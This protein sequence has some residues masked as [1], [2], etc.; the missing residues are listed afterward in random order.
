MKRRLPLILFLFC[1]LLAYP[2][3]AAAGTVTAVINT[4]SPLDVIAGEQFAIEMTAKNT[5]ADPVEVVLSGDSGG[6]ASIVASR[7]ITLGAEEE[8]KVFLYGTTW[9]PGVHALRVAVNG[10]PQGNELLIRVTD[11]VLPPDT[12]PSLPAP[13]LTVSKVAFR[14]EVPDLNSS[15]TI[16]ITFKNSSSTEARNVVVSLD[17][18]KNFEVLTLTNKVN[19]AYAWGGSTY[20]ASYTIRAKPDRE[21]NMVD[22][23][24]A[25]Q[26]EDGQGAY[27]E[28]L[29]LPLGDV[30]AQPENAPFLKLGTFSVEP[31]GD[32]GN[33]LLRFQL[34]NLGDA[35]AKPITLRFTGEQVFPRESSNVIFIPSL[36]AKTNTEVTIKMKVASKENSAYSIPVS[37]S[38]SGEKGGEYSGQESLTVSADKLGLA[39]AAT[40]AGTPR[41]MLSKYLLSE[42]QILA[43]NT[44]RLALSIENS[45]SVQ[46]RNIKISLGVI[47]VGGETGGTVFS[48]VNSSNSFYIDSIGPKKTY[49][50][51]IDL[52]VDPNAAAKTYI[53]PVEI[54]Y[55]DGTGKGYRV[56]EMVNIPVIQESRLQVLAVEVPPMASV[57]QPIPVTAEFVN[58]GKVALKNFLISIEGDFQKENATYF[59]ASLEMGVSDYFMGMIFPQQEGMISG[60]VIFTY[61]DNTNKEVRVEK[62]FEV[63]VQAMMERPE[64]P[65]EYPP[66]DFPYPGG[67]VSL[68]QRLAASAKWLVPL[69]AVLIIAAFI[70]VKRLRAKRGEM[71]NEDF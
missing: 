60:N 47:Q 37:L 21:S 41:V 39:G 25:Y 62:P 48:P 54:E 34:R 57:G 56:D 1:T 5:S 18:G 24:F 51:E 43:G 29:N 66:P 58:V 10:V 11:P 14:P 45:S 7:T 3:L 33:F 68:L 16:D 63:N 49:V 22:V 70:V 42:S 36:A 8:R 50:R 52:Y 69:L 53:V 28:T 23:R 17:G 32:S 2:G 40:V 55:E 26:Y 4:A 35:A 27:T 9:L 65:G 67:K 6:G 71:F 19:F 59:L 44:I 20:V 30:S 31:E 12:A 61:T 15:F 13:L 46:V 64:F 38:Y